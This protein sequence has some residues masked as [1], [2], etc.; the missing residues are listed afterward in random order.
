MRLQKQKCSETCRLSSKD[1]EIYLVHVST[2]RIITSLLLH[3][4]SQMYVHSFIQFTCDMTAINN[5]VIWN[6]KKTWWCLMLFF[7]FLLLT[8]MQ[9]HSSRISSIYHINFYSSDLRCI[10]GCSFSNTHPQN[11]YYYYYYFQRSKI[12][13]A[14]NLDWYNLGLVF[15]NQIHNNL[16]KFNML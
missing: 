1:S 3:I 14:F 6:K 13:I 8:S 5:G 12:L 2:Y 4:V 7:F 10:Y 11:I 15:E 16:L 9:V